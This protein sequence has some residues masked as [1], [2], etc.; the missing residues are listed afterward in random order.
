MNAFGSNVTNLELNGINHYL[1]FGI[2]ENRNSNLDVNEYINRIILM[3]YSLKIQIQLRDYILMISW[4]KL[5]M[6]LE[7]LIEFMKNYILL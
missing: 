6:I 7:F 3:I 4:T 1:N 5:K 2:K